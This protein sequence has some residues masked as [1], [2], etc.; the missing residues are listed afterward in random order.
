MAVASLILGSIIGSAGAL[1]A[2]LVMDAAFVTVC[3]IYFA[4]G[5]ASIGLSAFAALHEDIGE[6]TPARASGS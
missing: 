6:M 3:G 4:A 5:L 2:W 1:F